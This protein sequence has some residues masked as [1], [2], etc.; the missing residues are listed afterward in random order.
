MQLQ[1]TFSSFGNYI[2]NRLKLHFNNDGQPVPAEEFPVL[3]RSA[4]PGKSL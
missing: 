4:F 1:Q 2:A 3:E